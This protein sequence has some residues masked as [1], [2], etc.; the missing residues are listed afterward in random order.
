MNLSCYFSLYWD[1]Y[2]DLVK[3]DLEDVD[4]YCCFYDEYNVVLDM[5]VKYYFDIICVVFQDF[6]LLCGEWVVNGE[7]VDLLVIC[8]IVLLSIE[9]E[10]DDIVGFGQIEVV[11]VLCIGIVV[12]CCE[13]FIVEGVGYYGIFSGCCWCEVVYL[14]VCDFFVVYVEVLVVKVMKKKSNVILLW[15]KVG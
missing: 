13:Y 8:D 5:L 15:C 11:Q 10:L 9:G 4:V 7:K 1:F 12:D 6:L 3:G 2:I 14:K